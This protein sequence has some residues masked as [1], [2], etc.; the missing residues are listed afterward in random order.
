MACIN[1]VNL[2]T[3]QAVRRSK[4]VGIKKVLGGNRKQLFWQMIGETA[5]IVLI[6]MVVAIAIAFICLPFIRNIASIPENVNLISLSMLLFTLLIGITVTIFAG[7]LSFV[8]I[9]RI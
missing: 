4:E 2:S 9:V 5:I 7:T 1:F 8:D 3:A 6:S